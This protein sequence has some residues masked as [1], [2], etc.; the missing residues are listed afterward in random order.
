[1][2]EAGGV[3]VNTQDFL[4]EVQLLNGTNTTQV[5]NCL[6]AELEQAQS[7]RRQGFS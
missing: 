2:H 3:V 5:F 7:E 6:S 1:M 4:R